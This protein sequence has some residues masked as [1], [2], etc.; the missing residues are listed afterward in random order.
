MTEGHRSDRVSGA[1]E[2]LLEKVS[3]VARAVPRPI[4][5]QFC[6]LLQGLPLEPDRAATGAVLRAVT[7]HSARDLLAELV[8]FWRRK[9]SEVRPDQLSWALRA[10]GCA[11]EERRRQQSVELVW[12][13]PVV[14]PSTL[15]RTEQALLEL[16]QGAQR[17]LLLVT[18]AAYRVPQ[19]S[20]ALLAAADR[21]VEVL[22]IAESPD[23]SGGKVTF[24]GFQALGG[25]LAR[26][27]GL[28]IWPREQREQ[29]PAGRF[30]SLHAKCAV[31]D[32]TGVF[33]SSANLTEHAFNLNMELG[34]LIRGGE[35]P[36]QVAAHLRRLIQAGVL[37]RVP[38][39]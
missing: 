10:A 31:A 35:M 4:L 33:I 27:A 16:I 19:V 23:A 11:D 2:R 7:Q 3:A 12:T 5:E 20:E 18:F 30:G 25:R 8:S 28:Y 9:A 13:G 22:F 14:G 1:Q 29:D 34:V 24:A 21:E 37:E 15:R 32:D 36:R 6:F 38:P 26:K 17:S 39:E